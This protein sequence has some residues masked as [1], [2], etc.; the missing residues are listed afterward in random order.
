[1]NFIKMVAQPGTDE[2]NADNVVYHRH[3]DGFWYI[4]EDHIGPLMKVGGFALAPDTVAPPPSTATRP[5]DLSDVAELARQLPADETRS[6]L[7]GAIDA[8][9]KTAPKHFVK[10][11]GSPDVDGF[12]HDGVRYDVDDKGFVFA[13]AEAV[14]HLT[15]GSGFQVVGS[16][17]PQPRRE[18]KAPDPSPTEPPVAV[19]PVLPALTIPG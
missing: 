3:E 16:V 9:A 7:L 15:R 1:M 10:L 14:E 13:P 5:L 18:F 12:S 6:R 2:A 8:V 11:Q 4:R 19:A 17:W